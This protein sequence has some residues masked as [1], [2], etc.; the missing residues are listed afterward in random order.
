M[1]KDEVKREHKESEGDP[2]IKGKRKQLHQEMIQSGMVEQ[3][4]KASALVTNP[5][6]LAIALYYK[7]EETPLP[8]VLAKAEGALAMRLMRVAEEENVP[9]M[10]NVPLARSLYEQTEIDQYV[11]S[12][13]L[14]PV[15]EVLRWAR[16][17]NP[18]R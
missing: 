10:R 14:E 7:P 6:H 18:D 11:P 3:T 2:H 13:L 17:L 12:D 5:T 1:T 9:I 16:D 15:A 8:L 4:R